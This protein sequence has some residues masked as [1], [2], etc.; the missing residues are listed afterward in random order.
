MFFSTIVIDLGEI[1]PEHYARS[2]HSPHNPMAA[3]YLY[4]FPS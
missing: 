2:T 3:H 1:D 4:S